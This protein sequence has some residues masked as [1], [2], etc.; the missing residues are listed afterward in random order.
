[1]LGNR[2]AAGVVVVVAGLCLRKSATP[3]TTYRNTE[4]CAPALSVSRS[5]NREEANPF[6]FLLN[7]DPRY[8]SE[9]CQ[10]PRRVGLDA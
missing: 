3:R 4:C 1:M 5:V 6:G 8:C 2:F 10:S 7:G 9:N